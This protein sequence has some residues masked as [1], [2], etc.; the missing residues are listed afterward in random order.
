MNA[1][2]L[3]FVLCLALT[4]PASAESWP[5]WRGPK[6]D[7]IS[8]E[9]GLPVDFS[10]KKNLAWKLDLPGEGS[11]TPCVWGHKIF[12]TCAD[13]SNNPVA[14]CV[15]TDGKALW[16]VPLGKG[17][18]PGR[19]D[20]GNAASPSPSTDGKHVWFCVGTGAVA[21][22]DFEGKEVWKFDAQERYG[23]FRYGYGMHSTPV[24]YDGKLY[25]QLLHDGGQNVICI[26]AATG[27]EDWKVN[28]QSD[29]RAEC[30]HSYASPFIWTDGKN[31]LLITHGNDYTVAHEL[32][33]GMEVWRV[34]DL[35]GKEGKYNSTLRFVASPVCTPN[36]IVVP[37]A[38][39]GPVVGVNPNARGRVN[40]ESEYTI[41]RNRA[42]TPDVPSPLVHDGLV[43]IVRENASFQC[44]DAATGKEKYP[45]Q[46]LHPGR[47][48]ASPVYAD[49]KI[50][51]VC[52]D[53]GHV[54]VIKAGPEYELLAENHLPDNVAASPAVADGR[55]Y[56]HGYKALYAIGM[57]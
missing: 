53:G 2:R 32:K 17:G 20:E 35:N 45:A 1:S 10:D 25:F 51:A 36:L 43:Y 30:L 15:S 19:K 9:K 50:Y 44:W 29:G 48:R 4:I 37:T 8:N 46:R 31:A 13:E 52:R 40:A 6:N 28:R 16:R 39:G 33:D 47:Y 18:R 41:W 38:K 55:I 34:G 21:C 22:L 56:F 3:A 42:G 23:K 27:K 11:S 7:G 26:D 49:G 24:L 5:Q 57:K 54:S 14:M 12:L